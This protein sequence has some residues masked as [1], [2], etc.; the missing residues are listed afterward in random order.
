M[1]GLFQPK[2]DTCNQKINLWTKQKFLQ[3]GSLIVSL[4]FTDVAQVFFDLVRRVNKTAPSRRQTTKKK[5]KCCPR[6]SLS[7]PGCCRICWGATPLR[8]LRALRIFYYYLR[9][10]LTLTVQVKNTAAQEIPPVVNIFQDWLI[11][12]VFYA[13]YHPFST[14]YD[15]NVFIIRRWTSHVWK[16]SESRSFGNENDETL[17]LLFLLFTSDT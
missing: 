8:V 5:R 6:K 9:I 16:V 1:L 12:L 17:L 15:N 13:Y 14:N 4:I 3:S 10:L 11:I 2:S 7:C